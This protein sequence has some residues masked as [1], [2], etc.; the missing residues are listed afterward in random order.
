[1]QKYHKYKEKKVDNKYKITLMPYKK[2]GKIF[3]KQICISSQML[4]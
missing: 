4:F 3:T 1:M 2:L